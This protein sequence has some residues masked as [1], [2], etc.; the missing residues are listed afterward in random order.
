MEFWVPRSQIKKWDGMTEA[1][2]R[3]M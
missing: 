3:T 2:L 1:I